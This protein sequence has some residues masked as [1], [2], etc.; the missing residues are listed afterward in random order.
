MTPELEQIR[1]ALKAGDK[2]TAR[3]LLPPLIK[4]QPTPD[5]WKLAAQACETKEDA[6]KC[7][8]KALQLDPYHSRANSLLL[9]LEDLKPPTLT[10]WERLTGGTLPMRFPVEPMPLKKVG[11]SAE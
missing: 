1:K 6:L 9:K 5:L 8:R 11:T 2:A 3:A 7:L 10:E 4:G